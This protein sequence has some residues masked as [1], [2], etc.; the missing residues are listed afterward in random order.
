MD[1]IMIVED[2][3]IIRDLLASELQ[4]RGFE[5]YGVT[6]FSKVFEDFQKEEP[7]LVLLDIQLPHFDGYHWGRK[8][9]EVSKVPIIYISSLSTN[10]DMLK[11]IELGADDYITKPFSLEILTMKITA[12]L[13]RSY[14]YKTTENALEHRGLKINIDTSSATVGEQVVDLSKNEYKLLFILMKNQGKIM[15]REKLL[16]ALWEDERFVDDNTLTVNINR[17]RKKIEQAGLKDF[18]QTKVGKGYVIA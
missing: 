15:S 14:T 4:K 9:R 2:E 6:D 13:R 7:K 3:K 8:I 11:A 12:L 16:R 5:T 17:L 1:K 10:L 18:I